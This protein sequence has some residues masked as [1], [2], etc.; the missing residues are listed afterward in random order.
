VCYATSLALR[1]GGSRDA[2]RATGLLGFGIAMAAA[3]LG[4]Y[5]VYHQRVGVT[6]A[7]QRALPRE[8][9]PV[10]GASELREGEPRRVAAGNVRVLLVRRGGRIFAL[11]ETCSHFGG[12]LAEGR[13][14]DESVRCPWHGSRFSLR[15]GSVLEGP[16]TFPQPCY[17]TRVHDGQIE[18]RAVRR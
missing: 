13:L 3:Y 12:P 11:G 17:D 1:R 2:G 4:G 10:L 15:D 6:H 16:A 18:V 14:E 5:L 8:F 9:V 7:D